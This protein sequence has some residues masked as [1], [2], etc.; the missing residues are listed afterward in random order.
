[1]KFWYWIWFYTGTFF[2]EAVWAIG[3]WFLLQVAYGWLFLYLPDLGGVAYWAHIGGFVFGAV[4]G[5][6]WKFTRNA[7]VAKA[8]GI[9]DKPKLRPVAN[10]RRENPNQVLASLMP[11]GNE[12]E[13]IQNFIRLARFYGEARIEPQYH[14]KAAD[15]FSDRKAYREAAAVYTTFLLLYPGHPL[16]PNIKYYLGLLLI[17]HLN[18]PRRGVKYLQQLLSGSIA[19]EALLEEGRKE[20]AL[21]SSKLPPAP[22]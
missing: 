22:G 17:Y 19:D 3:F 20:L 7:S 9:R 2:L 14:L 1:M 18:Q 10:L 6:T 21:V 12:I 8:I 15:I 4:I 13:F 11:P 5:I 16:T